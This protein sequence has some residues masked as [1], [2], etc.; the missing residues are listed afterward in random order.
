[1]NNDKPDLYHE[2]QRLQ[3]CALHSLNSLFQKPLFNKQK[4][5]SIVHEYDKSWCWNEYSTLFTGN[6]D[7]TIILDALKQQGYTLRA[8][9]VNE[10]LDIF[11]FKDCLGLLLNIPLERP[12]FDR[13]PL[14]RSWTKPGRHWFS[15]KSINGE[16]YY[17]LD[18]KLSRPKLIGNE[19]DLKQYLNTL[20]RTETYMY[21][22]IEE[23]MVEKFEQK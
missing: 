18:S 7:L 11:H 4:L 21:I 2:K 14:V 5:D 9:D 17:N 3:L 23:T 20:N 8:I 13:L 22:V 10:S 12:F 16:N 15:I 6:Y 1:M 19:T